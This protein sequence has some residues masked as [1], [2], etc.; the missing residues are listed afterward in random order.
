MNTPRFDTLNQRWS[1]T[2]FDQQGRAIELEIAPVGDHSA[3]ARKKLGQIGGGKQRGT[4]IFGLP[5]H[6]G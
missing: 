5:A 3:A 1:Q 2:I 4:L 6:R